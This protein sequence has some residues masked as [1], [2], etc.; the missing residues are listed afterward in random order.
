MTIK[1]KI[2]ALF[3]NM[4][5]KGFVLGLLVMKYQK[6]ER[7]LNIILA[8]ASSG[9][10]A[11][12]AV[13]KNF[14]FI[15]SSIIAISQVIMALK[16]LFP[17]TKFIK[18]L[19]TRCSKI[20]LLNIECERLWN[21]I[22]NGKLK[23]D[24]LDQYYYDYSKAYSEILNL[25]DDIVIDTPKIIENK[26]NLRMANYLKTYFNIQISLPTK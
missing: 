18:E 20:D 1:D 23:E 25:S 11:A 22:Q 6:L 14:P 5:F 26:A 13:W 19:N 10:I 16:P 2:W 24:N 4:K 21:K 17:F 12:W 7:N 15:W 9:S 8:I 3:C